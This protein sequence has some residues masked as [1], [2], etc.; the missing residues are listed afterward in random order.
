MGEVRDSW[1]SRE[2]VP[3]EVWGG[4]RVGDPIEVIHIFGGSYLRN[5]VF[6][7]P[8]NFV[9]DLGLLAAEVLVA[10]VMIVQMLIRRRQLS[11]SAS[12]F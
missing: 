3:P 6:V 5:G 1:A 4:M 8:G 7:E 2:R 12:E 10:A 9:F 11:V